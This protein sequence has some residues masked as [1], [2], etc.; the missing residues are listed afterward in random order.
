MKYKHKC[1]YMKVRTYVLVVSAA[2][3]MMGFGTKNARPAEGIHPGDLAPGIESFEQETTLSFRNDSGRY[4]LLNFWAAYDAES[5]ARNIRLSNE[6]SKLDSDRI[7]FCSFSQDEKESVFTETVKTDQ[8]D[9]SMQFYE[10]RESASSLYRQ[11]NRKGGFHNYLIND[12][13]V[14][15][16]TN[17]TP[18]RLAGILK[19]V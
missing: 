13:G 18:G 15:I 14:I 9:R 4:T 19:G 1:G 5:R 11:Y 7:A 17:V 8:L 6:V 3:L 10:G 12:K 16:A 2:L